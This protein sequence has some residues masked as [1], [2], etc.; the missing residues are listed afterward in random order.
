[1]TL[2]RYNVE[3]KSK[4]WNNRQKDKIKQYSLQ[5][6]IH[7]GHKG[8]GRIIITKVMIFLTLVILRCLFNLCDGG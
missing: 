3:V 2:K 1:M 5:E 8:S 6:Q 4:E 7:K